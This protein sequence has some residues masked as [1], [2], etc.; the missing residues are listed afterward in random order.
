MLELHW[1]SVRQL[2]WKLQRSELERSKLQRRE[3]ERGEL[4]RRELERYE[5]ERRELERRDRRIGQLQQ[6]RDGRVGQLQRSLVL[7]C[8]LLGRGRLR[9]LGALLLRKKLGRT[10]PP[11]WKRAGLAARSFEELV[12]PVIEGASPEDRTR[13]AA[14]WQKRGGLELRVAAGFSA[15]SVELFEHGTVP[16]VYE[17][18]SQAVRDEVHHAQISIEMAAKYR[19]DAPVWP[20]PEPLHIPP[21]APTKGAMHATLYVIAMCCINETVACGVLEAAHSQA[22]S[23][24][25]R[26]ALATILSDEID[27]ARAGWAHI[28]SPYVTDE[29]RRALPPW[30]H[31]LHSV[32]LREL[33]ED[34]GPLPGENF[35][36]HGM[37]S[38]RRSQEV[39]YATLVDVMFPGYRRAGIDPSLAEQWAV[40]A[41]PSVA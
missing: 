7:G 21:F 5:L 2:G 29:M 23:P 41:F 39:V 27:H 17:I 9:R 12:D 26:A 24:L 31:R 38:R 30:L 32:K 6:R 22:K 18:L 19:G 40:G 16:P 1:L 37:L 25:A 13:L 35:A 20:E 34:E 33:V 15:L 11:W 36:M 8:F 14:I 3:L 28:A 10:A 4:E